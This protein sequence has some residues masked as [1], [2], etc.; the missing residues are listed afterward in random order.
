[1]VRIPRRE[2]GCVHAKGFDPIAYLA[3]HENRLALSLASQDLAA[4]ALRQTETNPDEFR[5]ALY[6][7]ALRQSFRCTPFGIFAGVAFPQWGKTTQLVLRADPLEPF[8]RLSE[9]FIAE[10]YGDVAAETEV[11]LNSSAFIADDVLILDTPRGGRRVIDLTAKILTTVRVAWRAVRLGD[12]HIALTGSGWN[13]D[14]E[15]AGLIKTLLEHR[16]L[17][18]QKHAASDI[19]P[20][21]ID[22]LHDVRR[23]FISTCFSGKISIKGLAKL[24]SDTDARFP[25]CASR[26]KFAVDS[27]VKLEK[28]TL[29]EHLKPLVEQAADLLVRLSPPLPELSA[30]KARFLEKYGPRRKVPLAEAIDPE[31]G[32]GPLSTPAVS[33]E[34][35]RRDRTLIRLS[36]G[37]YLGADEV[38]LTDSDIEDLSFRDTVPP[39]S[40]DLCFQIAAKSNADVDK[41]DVLLVVS[42]N[43]GAPE[44]GRHFGRFLHLMEEEERY[45]YDQFV[46]CEE[47]V[48]TSGPSRALVAQLSFTPDRD[49][50]LDVVRVPTVRR[51][52]IP[53]NRRASPDM[54]AIPVSDLDLSIER[55]RL[56]LYSNFLRSEI[57]VRTPHMLRTV[58]EDPVVQLLHVLSFDGVAMLSGFDWGLANARRKLPRVR[59]GKIVVRPAEWKFERRLLTEP[60]KLSDAALEDILG[61]W[62]AMW[63]V[64]DRIALMSGDNFLPLDLTTSDHRRILLEEARSGSQGDDLIIREVLPAWDQSWVNRGTDRFRSEFVV[65]LLLKQKEASKSDAVTESARVAREMPRVVARANGIARKHIGSDW[66]FV[67]FYSR[68]DSQNALLCEEFWPYLDTLTADANSQGWFFVRY[69]DGRHHLRVRVKGEAAWLSQTALP[70]ILEWA[71]SLEKSKAIIDFSV[72]SYDRETSRYGGEKS[73]EI[74]ERHFMQETRAAL[75]LLSDVEHKRRS[76][77]PE[78]LLAAALMHAQSIAI[79]AEYSEAQ[80]AVLQRLRPL[81]PNR[82]VRANAFDPM[83]LRAL[84]ERDGGLPAQTSQALSMADISAR[85]LHSELNKLWRDRQMAFAP[86]EILPDLQHMAANRILGVNRESENES[87]AL[88]WRVYGYLRHVTQGTFLPPV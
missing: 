80:D 34:I 78:V 26:G 33:N 67:S 73:L 12:L 30:F 54:T 4:R 62:R 39:P 86:V 60:Q 85:K 44:G 53:V 50:V 7:Y 23:E 42:P 82:L 84:I 66:L 36:E 9:A 2:V 11:I 65:P 37:G 76:D 18:P 40:I 10:F 72:G 68:Q 27:R 75:L 51:Y 6:R 56:T 8:V 25:S 61:R 77:S 24:V 69:H 46:E 57:V 88:L 79:G 64:P 16:I 70:S 58:E 63:R 28:A 5:L 1:M 49:H 13:D 29:G 83:E 43:V 38:L 31:I 14:S 74:V 41:G 81:V 87:L 22:G 35:R 20:Q 15:A 32:I 45:A 17:V 21:G 55:G 71:S 47:E 52:E 48:L 19:S 59:L 3:H